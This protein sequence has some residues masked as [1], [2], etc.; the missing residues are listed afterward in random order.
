MTVRH[1]RLLGLLIR[2]KTN[3]WERK[4]YAVVS[5]GYLWSRYLSENIYLGHNSVVVTW[6]AATWT[7]AGGSTSPSISP[8][9]W[10]HVLFTRFSVNSRTDDKRLFLQNKHMSALS[11]GLRNE[12][13]VIGFSKALSLQSRISLALAVSFGYW[14]NPTRCWICCR[15]DVFSAVFSPFF[16]S[17]YLW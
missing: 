15:T 2:D 10:N 11:V 1:C 16:P 3:P 12:W 8:I 5:V 4:T 6:A 17:R 7:R 13:A 9:N 14:W